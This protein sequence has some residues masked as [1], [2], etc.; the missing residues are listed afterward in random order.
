MS[1]TRDEK[2]A[3]DR[4]VKPNLGDKKAGNAEVI[5]QSI[6]FC[7]TIHN[8]PCTLR[9][10]VVVVIDRYLV[11]RE[12]KGGRERRDLES[13]IHPVQSEFI[14]PGRPDPPIVWTWT[15]WK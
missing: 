14:S 2:K 4:S 7:I 11:M 5:Y 13:W 3:E 12:T 10:S 9:Q 15:G 6:V 8:G 1:L